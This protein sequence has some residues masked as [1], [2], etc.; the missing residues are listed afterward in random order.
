VAQGIV[1]VI[2][3]AIGLLAAFALTLE[4]FHLLQDPGSVPSCDFSLLVQCGANLNSPQGSIFGFPNPVIGLMAWPVVITIG[5]ALIG[6]SRFPRWFWLGLNLGVAGA[7]AFVIWL[8]GTS[9]FALATLCPWCMVTWSVVIPLFWM[10]TFDNLRTGRLPLGSAMRR[11]AAAAYSWIPLITLGCL[12]V[13][14]VIAQL[15]LDILN[16]L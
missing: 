6:G 16:Y 2:L 5:V 7:L 4:K 1:F 14:A 12:I 8:I 10:V 15:R 13:I 11:L 3:G 9:I